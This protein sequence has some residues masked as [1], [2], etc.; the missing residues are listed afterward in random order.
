MTLVNIYLL[1]PPALQVAS[2]S[3]TLNPE[4]EALNPK[5]EPQAFF[6]RNYDPAW[7]QDDGW[8]AKAVVRFR[9]RVASVCRKEP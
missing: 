1:S 4:P 8:S 5:K 6:G 7:A 9:A 3:Q 2:Q